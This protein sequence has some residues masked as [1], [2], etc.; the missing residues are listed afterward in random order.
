MGLL[1]FFKK[2]TDADSAPPRQAM[3]PELPFKSGRDAIEY[4]KKYMRTDRQPQN[5]VTG[6]IARPEFE[7]G[8]LYARVLIPRGDGFIEILTVTKIKAIDST[9]GR[10]RDINN[11]S[12]IEDLGLA[13]GDLVTVYLSAQDSEIRKNMPKLTVG[14][15]S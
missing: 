3:P 5:L 15:H 8:I 2:L 11:N 7:N 10:R 4:A 13:F 1:D 6:L 14:L 9:Y 12:I